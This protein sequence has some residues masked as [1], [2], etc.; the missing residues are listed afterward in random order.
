MYIFILYTRYTDILYHVCCIQHGS[1]LLGN[2]FPSLAMIQ[3]MIRHESSLIIFLLVSPILYF[4]KW[5]EIE[6][7]NI[8]PYM[9]MGWKTWFND[10]PFDF[11]GPALL[12]APG[13]WAN[14]RKSVLPRS[15]KCNPLFQLC[16]GLLYPNIFWILI[17][18]Y[19]YN[20]NQN[21]NYNYMYIYIMWFPK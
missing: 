14:S 15:S 18:R 10:C 11:R 2:S 5:D 8:F 16:C 17:I 20:N 6:L 12:V 19:I 1:A 9:F 4:S 7:T 13:I 21:Y 3:R